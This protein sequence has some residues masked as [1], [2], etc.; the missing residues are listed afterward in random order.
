MKPKFTAI[1]LVLI[2]LVALLMVE[3]PMCYNVPEP[4]P[5]EEVV[6]YDARVVDVINTQIKKVQFYYVRITGNSMSPAIDD[7]D[8]C[9]CLTKENYNIGDIVSFFVPDKGKVELISH[10]IITEE[11]DKF[12]TKGDFNSIED[13]WVI[14]EDQIFCQIPEESLFNKFKFAIESGGRFGIF[15]IVG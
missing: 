11:D 8:T 3:T 2:A 14:N 4:K 9:L 13:N 15:S 1:I 10:R 7:G 6:S 12:T 5:R